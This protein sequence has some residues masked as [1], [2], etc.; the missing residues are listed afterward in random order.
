MPLTLVKAATFDE[1]VDDWTPEARAELERN[2]WNG[3]VGQTLVSESEL[4]RVWMIHLEPG[5]RLPFH[6]HVLDYFWTALLPG[7]ARSRYGDGSVRIYEYERGETLHLSFAAGSSMIHDLT[8]VGD[9][10]IGF[11]TVE[12]KD[13][14]NRPL[15]LRQT[16]GKNDDR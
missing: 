9:R 5:D 3:N 16:E 6:R 8:N 11:V 10:P 15:P 13:G 12:F 7:T 2:E 1:A 14:P 4:V